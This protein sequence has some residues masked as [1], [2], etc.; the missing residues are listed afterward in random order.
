[1]IQ[2]VINFILI[3][4]LSAWFFD[5]LKQPLWL[6]SAKNFRRSPLKKADEF[7]ERQLATPP[8]AG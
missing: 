5:Y 8:P 6:E 3:Y 1:M 2:K 4:H 7:V